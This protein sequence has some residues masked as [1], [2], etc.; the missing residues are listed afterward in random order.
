MGVGMTI[1]IWVGGWLIAAFLTHWI[2]G[3]RYGPGLMLSVVGAAFLVW[4]TRRSSRGYA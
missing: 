4:L 2:W 1:L 3:D